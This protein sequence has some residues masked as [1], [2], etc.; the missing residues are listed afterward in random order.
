MKKKPEFNY[1]YRDSFPEPKFENLHMIGKVGKFGVG[2][3]EG[4]ILRVMRFKK[5]TDANE[6]KYNL[7]SVVICAMMAQE[8]S[9]VDLLPNG[10]G[11]GG[12]GLCHMQSVVAAS[13]G[14][15]VYDNCK[16]MVCNGKDKRSCRVP[17]GKANHAKKLL[18]ELEKGKFNRK[19]LYQLDDR[20]HPILNLDAVGR[21]LAY[22]MDGNP[23]KIKGQKLGPFRTAICRYA[24][25]YTYETY[26]KEVSKIMS[27]LNDPVFM[28]KVEDEFNRIN[29]NLKINGKPG[30]YDLYIEVSQNQAYNYGLREYM[31][32]PLY[33][34]KNSEIVL[35]TYKNF[36]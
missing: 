21:M 22:H 8:S 11:D 9:G 19:N 2:S 16:A 27:M 3:Y 10:L 25:K 23:L 35:K 6:K 36:Q 5:I 20:L 32:T 7:P 17:G 26:W 34:P 29:P 24:G 30:D 31:E 14:C 12:F 4:K 15:K 28:Q 33:K 1:V 18:K 13:F